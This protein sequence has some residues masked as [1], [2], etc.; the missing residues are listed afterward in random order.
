[1]KLLAFSPYAAA[2][3]KQQQPQHPAYAKLKEAYLALRDTADLDAAPIPAGNR[4]KRGQTDR[5]LPAVRKALVG[6]GFYDAEFR[7]DVQSMPPALRHAA[8]ARETVLDSSLAEAIKSFQ[9]KVNLKPSGNLE[10]ATVTALN[11]HSPRENLDRLAINMDR[12]R[13]LPKNLGDRYVMMNQPAFELRLIDKG[14][15]VWR[16]NVIVGK[17]HNQ[18]V[19]FHDEM[20]TVVFNP[21]WGVPQSIIAKEMLPILRKDPVLSRPQRL[22]RDPAQRQDRQVALDQLARLRQQDSAL[23][24]A[25]AER[26]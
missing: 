10:P 15:Q 9:T 13:W 8:L 1:M 3:L 21:S 6:L 26:R 4:V 17:P 14:K 11:Q 2:W 22:S 24:A 20:E 16:T 18:T 23:R 25:A 12:M 19:A 5:R 7:V